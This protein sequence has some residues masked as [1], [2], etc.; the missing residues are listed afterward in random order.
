MELKVTEEQM[1]QLISVA[2]LQTLTP[3]KR[4]ELITGAIQALLA[5]NVGSAYDKRS[6]LQRLFEQEC[7]NVARL[8]IREHIESDPSA[9]A[10]VRSV[11]IEAFEKTFTGENRAAVVDRA[12]DAISGAMFQD[13]R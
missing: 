13:R 5:K 10:N 6:E 1:H 8:I 9:M 3:E 7:T 2:L 11:A 12:A 4:D